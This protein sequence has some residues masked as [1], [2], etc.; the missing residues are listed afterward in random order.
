ME[1]SARG[2]LGI[3]VAELGGNKGFGGATVV[4]ESSDSATF[5]SVVAI[6]GPTVATSST[7][8]RVVGEPHTAHTATSSNTV[9]STDFETILET[10]QWRDSE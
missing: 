7:G 5:S 6:S 2:L 3:A 1:R 9:C 10:L 4:S 8:A